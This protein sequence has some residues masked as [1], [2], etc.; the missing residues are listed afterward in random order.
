MKVEAVQC[1]MPANGKN[2]RRV[3]ENVRCNIH[4]KARNR[5]FDLLVSE[6]EP[7]GCPKADRNK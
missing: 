6:Q 5:E 7:V 1:A 2:V 3:L 4:A